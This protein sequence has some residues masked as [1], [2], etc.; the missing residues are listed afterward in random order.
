VLLGWDVLLGR[1]DVVLGRWDIVLGRQEVLLGR[2]EVL[3]RRGEVLL[4]WR[5][6]VFGHWL[7]CRLWICL[8]YILVLGVG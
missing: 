6:M 8:L 1:W 3:L 7:G 4:G 5:G 2:E